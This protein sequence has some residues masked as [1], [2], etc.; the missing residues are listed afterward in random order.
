MHN[1]ST[2][3]SN[4]CLY[5]KRH[6]KKLVKTSAIYLFALITMKGPVKHV[7]RSEEL[8]TIITRN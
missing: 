3:E 7:R 8:Y 1:R 6:L 5:S 2:S 4:Y